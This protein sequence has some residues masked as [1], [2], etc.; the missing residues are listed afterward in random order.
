MTG[1]DLKFHIYN[2]GG[3]PGFTESRAKF[4]AAEI[5]LGLDH[6]HS[7]GIVYRDC[8]PE[9]I[10][11]DDYGHVRIS[12][13]GLALQIPDGE[14]VRGRVGTVG[15]MAPEIID[16]EK[17]TFSPDYF[18]LGCLI[19]E[20]I[21]GRAPFRARKEK[22]KREEVDRRVKEM[23]EP[24][25]KKFSDHAV[26]ICRA[27]LKKSTRERLGCASGRHGAKEVMSHPW[28]SS[29]INWRRLKAG[30]D[31]PPF[32]PDPHAVY[33]K[34]VLDIE[35]FSTVKG[36]NLD[37]KDDT[38]Y[39]RF[40]TGAVSIAWQEEMIETKVFEDLNVFGPPDVNG[41]LPTDL[42]FNFIPEPEPKGCFP[43]LR[44]KFKKK[45]TQATNTGAALDTNT[46]IGTA[47]A[48]GVNTGPCETHN[49]TNIGIDEIVS[50]DKIS[51]ADGNS[52][53][54]KLGAS[55]ATQQ[56]STKGS[57][58]PAKVSS[59]KDAL[60]EPETDITLVKD[61]KTNGGDK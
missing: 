48:T 28:F 59:S 9:N 45:G 61:T 36:V 24:Y 57:G 56:D 30:K 53:N 23:D 49:T 39:Q 6:L 4:Y 10:L 8:K 18:S 50:A 31:K 41:G 17:Y 51:K 27:L 16:N 19:Y 11:L 34:D 46:T 35:Q 38:F 2:M 22:V 29:T 37:A 43:F 33:A 60:E 52:Q 47:S 15:Y 13:L 20:M 25:S 32:A 58:E 14:V 5:L 21:E 55:G 44:K 42:D 3:E 54:G 26:S 12:D 7:N 40:N 1:G